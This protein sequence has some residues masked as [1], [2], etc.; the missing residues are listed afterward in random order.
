[1]PPSSGGRGEKSHPQGGVGWETTIFIRGGPVARGG[2][3]IR[4]PQGGPCVCVCVLCVDGWGGGGETGVAWGR[5][6]DLGPARWDGVR[7]G[8][9]WEA[10]MGRL[11]E[12]G[13]RPPITPPSSR[14]PLTPPRFLHLYPTATPPTHLPTRPP[15]PPHSLSP[16]HLA[17]QEHLHRDGFQR[18]R[19]RERA[20]RLGGLPR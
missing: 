11:G 9:R 14:R 3:E 17:E 8:F 6:E 1:M 16:P 19:R 5:A 10:G 4:H 15:T 20:L 18:L 7:T 13:F 12:G 2:V